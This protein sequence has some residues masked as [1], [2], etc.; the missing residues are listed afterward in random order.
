M[1]SMGLVTW[2][3]HSALGGLTLRMLGLLKIV[4]SGEEG[5]SV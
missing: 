5:V 1:S 4:F 2:L 3:N